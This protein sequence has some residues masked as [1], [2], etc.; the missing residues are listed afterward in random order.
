LI[1]WLLLALMISNR[2]LL[3]R[4]SWMDGIGDIEGLDDGVVLVIMITAPVRS[5]KPSTKFAVHLCTLNSVRLNY[6]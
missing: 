3:F 2:L 1:L 5:S 4:S 6:V